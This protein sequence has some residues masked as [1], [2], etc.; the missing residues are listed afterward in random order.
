MDIDTS[1]V[2]LYPFFVTILEKNEV[3][4]EWKKGYLIKLSK[5]EISVCVH[6]NYRGITPLP[7]PGKVFNRVLL[8]RFKDAVDS[9]PIVHQAGFMKNRSCADQ[10]ATLHIILEQSLY[11]SFIRL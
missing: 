3:P 7:I 9:H 5:K 11:V 6:L 10:I 8:I 1:V 4:T 2:L